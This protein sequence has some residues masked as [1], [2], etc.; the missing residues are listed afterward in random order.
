MRINTNMMAINAHRLLRE[1]DYTRGKSLQRLSSGLRIN[2][3]QDDAAGLAISEK[4][5]SQVNG[6]N[7]AVSN[8]QD[9]MNLVQ[10]AEGALNETEAILQ[11][12]R[13]LA[14]QGA[15]DTL[16]VSDRA[17]IVDELQALVREIDRIAKDTQFN[18]KVLLNG[19]IA[20]TQGFTFQVG[21]NADQWMN[22]VINTANAKALG[23]LMTQI[24]VD[25]AYNASTTIF[26]LDKAIHEVSSRRSKLGAVI[27][28]MEH[29]VANLSVQRENMSASESRIRDLDMAAEMSTLTKQQILTQSGQAMLAQANQLPQQILQLLRG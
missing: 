29:T 19:G 4:F 22:V 28:R 26:N 23:V 18:S 3:A 14:V 5:R 13:Q 11:R 25:N 17:N 16:T 20:A 27:N 10:T 9:A 24:S 6:L 21:A 7:Q 1:N 12:M 15:N 2:G 8:T